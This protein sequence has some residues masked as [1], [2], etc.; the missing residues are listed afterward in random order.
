MMTST[1]QSLEA[2]ADNVAAITAQQ[3]P[4]VSRLIQEMISTLAD[5]FTA[6]KVAD[7]SATR[8]QMGL[9]SQNL[10]SLKCS[11]DMAMRGYYTQS[12][13]LLRGVCENWIA[14]HYI[15]Q[16]PAK[17]DRWLCGT[18]KPPKH[19]EMLKALG[20]DFVEAKDDARGWYSTLCRFAHTDALVVLPHLGTYHGE[21]CAFFGAKFKPLLFR[22]CA[23]TTSVC[24]SL[25]LRDVSQHVSL[26]A[27]WQQQCNAQIESILQFIQQ[28]NETSEKTKEAGKANHTS[29]GTRQPA[30]GSPK[31]S[32]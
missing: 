8:A 32:M 29:E 7:T 25:M 30:D 16:F 17:A 12:T 28:E 11:V 20:T 14:F 23:Y 5:G 31:P 24:T 1:W 18:N 26:D 19:S 13:N 27:T 3:E 10:N 6:A 15:T 21:A 4:G 22:T 9:F 2:E